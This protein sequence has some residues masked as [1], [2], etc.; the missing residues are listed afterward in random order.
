M[1]EKDVEMVYGTLLS[2][3]GMNENVKIDLR[4]SRKLALLL[5]QVIGKGLSGSEVLPE[6]VLREATAELEE[7]AN[8]CLRKAGLEELSERLRVLSSK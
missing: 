2:V 1:T 4:I 5:N 6:K 8:E 3:P 7:I